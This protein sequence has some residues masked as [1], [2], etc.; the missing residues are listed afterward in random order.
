MATMRRDPMHRAVPILL[1]GCLATL[2][3]AQAQNQVHSVTP[4]LSVR[5]E[6]TDNVDGVSDASLSAKRSEDILTVSP[7]LEIRHQGPNTLLEGR[8]GLLAEHR[9][10]GTS[11]DRVVPDGRLKLRTEPGGRG[12]GL[13]ASLQAQQVKPAVSSSAGTSTAT[14]NTVTETEASVSP[15][16]ERKLNEQ[17]ELIA[18]AQGLH[19][20]TDPRLDTSREVRTSNVSAQFAIVRR[21]SPFGYALEASSLDER[22]K[23][24]T[25]DAA[26]SATPLRED[27]RTRQSTLRATLLY[28]FGLELETGLILGNEKDRRRLDSVSATGAS[29]IERN[30][31]GGFWGLQ[32]SWRPGPRTEVK[33]TVE[34]RKASRTWTFDASHRLRRTTFALTDRQ[35][36]TRNAPLSASVTPGSLPALPPT[37]SSAISSATSLPYSDQSTAL[38]SVQR[39]TGLRITYEGVR[40]ALGLV[41]GQFRARALIASGTAGNT[42]RSRYHGAE[43]SY[44]LTAQVTPNIGLRWSN[45]KDSAG[46][47]RKEQL[48]TMGLRMR[49]SPNSSLDAGAAQLSSRARTTP[50]AVTENTHTHSVYIRLEHRF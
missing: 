31:D 45:A 23:A 9:L 6:H 48:L 15:F 11:S 41:A 50:S 5:M 26:G 27:G 46:L 17:H 22:Q 34:D 19:A 39:T 21:P 14:A 25:P 28:A 37:S 38:L 43:L 30:F 29:E 1:L 40:A 18:R 33:G 4:T 36:A 7:A 16:F 3:A 47:T 13:E 24:E 20:R 10:R 12:A 49:L 32:A 42:D 2:E 44:R 8:F 35:I